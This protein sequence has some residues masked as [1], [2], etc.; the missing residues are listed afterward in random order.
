VYTIVSDF[1]AGIDAEQAFT[2][3]YTEAGGTLAGSVRIPL[4][5]PDYAPFL[6]RILDT[7]PDAIFVWQS[8]TNAAAFMKAVSD[9]GLAR[10]GIR[11]IG[12]NAADESQL[13]QI[14]DLALGVVTAQHYTH[15]LKN[16]ENQAFVVAW[17]AMHGA[18][19]DPTYVA[20][21]AWDG[22]ALIYHLIRTLDGKIDGDKAMEVIE[23]YQA[24]SPRGPF[25][26]DP[27]TR[28]AINDI[29][30]RKV[31]RVDG[32]LV[33]AVVDTIPAVKDPW[34]QRNKP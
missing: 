21:G 7:H 9:L 24:A 17:R 27:E 19:S 34:K 14:G 1:T 18:D 32:R 22:M 28:D 4:I 33:N 8:P 20:V 30:I 15:V 29:Y 12:D 11:V 16:P 2:A 31:E 25:R 26:I 10:A 3:G 23:G 6:Q 13:Q 5:N